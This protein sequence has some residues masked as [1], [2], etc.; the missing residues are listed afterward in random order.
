M[1]HISQCK[2]LQERWVAWWLCKLCQHTGSDFLIHVGTVCIL[3]A[4]NDGLEETCALFLQFTDHIIQYHVEVWVQL[5]IVL[6]VN[7]LIDDQVATFSS[8]GLKC[9][10]L[11]REDHAES[12]YT[13]W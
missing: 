12:G 9:T 5:N 6:N 10:A 8:R 4:E 2:L 13:A 3:S 11:C 1:V 7:S